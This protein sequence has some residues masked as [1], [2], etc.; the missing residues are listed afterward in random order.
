M[1]FC[2]FCEIS[3]PV[4]QNTSR[5]LLLK[6][7][8]ETGSDGIFALLNEVNS[9]LEDDSDNLRRYDTIAV[10]IVLRNYS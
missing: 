6:I 7:E 5:R 10:R 1:F 4:L 3:T 2:E 8:K 9:D